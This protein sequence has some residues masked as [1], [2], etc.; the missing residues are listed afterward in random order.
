MDRR[1]FMGPAPLADGADYVLDGLGDP[2]GMRK[3][4][5]QSERYTVYLRQRWRGVRALDV[6]FDAALSEFVGDM[7]GRE[8]GKTGWAKARTLVS[9]VVSCNPGLEGRLQYSEAR[10]E[11]WKCRLEVCGASETE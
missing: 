6:E 4:F 11:G 1:P 5:E 3:E 9:A 10:L 2:E 7:F 8:A